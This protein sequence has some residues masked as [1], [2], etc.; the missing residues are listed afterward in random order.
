MKRAD[1]AGKA[2]SISPGLRAWPIAVT[3][4]ADPGNL[5]LQKGAAMSGTANAGEN[6]PIAAQRTTPPARDPDIAVQEEYQ[7]ARQ[8]GGAQALELFIARHPDSPLADKAR[9]DLSSMK[10]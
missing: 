7:M 9:A 3:L 4:L 8:N 6:R 2:N 1:R 10:R 5:V